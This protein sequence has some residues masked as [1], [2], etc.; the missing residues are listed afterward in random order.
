M[1]RTVK[2]EHGHEV[3]AEGE[4]KSNVRAANGFT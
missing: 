1:Y 3:A 4:E 2:D